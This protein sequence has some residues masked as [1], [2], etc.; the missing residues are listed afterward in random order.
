MCRYILLH[1]FELRQE[2]TSKLLHNVR[3]V[4]G[5]LKTNNDLLNNIIVDARQINGIISG[6]EVVIKVFHLDG[7]GAVKTRGRRWG[8]GNSLAA[9]VGGGG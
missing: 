4:V 5:S 2:N 9:F 6:M 1:N 3:P 7:E 8:V